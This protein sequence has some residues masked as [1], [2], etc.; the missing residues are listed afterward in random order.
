MDGVFVVN[1]PEDITSFGVCSV[2]RKLTSTKKT[3]HTGTLDPMATGVLVVCTGSAGRLIEYM[4]E[5]VKRYTAGID[6]GLVSDTQDIWGEVRRISE[7]S[8]SR[9]E[10][11]RVLDSLTGTYM[12]KTPAFSARKVDGRA[13]YSYARNNEDVTLPEKKVTVHSIVLREFSPEHAV[14][15]VECSKGTY[16]RQLVSDAGEALGCGA[17]MSSLVRTSTDG[18]DIGSSHTLDELREAARQGA[19]GDMMLPPDCLISHIPAV[20]VER[21]DAGRIRNGMSIALSGGNFPDGTVRVYSPQGFVALGEVSRGT[22]RP[23]KVF[24]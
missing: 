24:R 18:F 9:Q 13:L 12:Q 11:M 1:K 22:L 8:F 16:I 10:L 19:I 14:I 2:I 6:F 4:P 20:C 17:V 15:D 7:P 5:A 3:G 21:D 23:R